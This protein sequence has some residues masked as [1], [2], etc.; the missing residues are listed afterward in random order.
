MKHTCHD[1]FILSHDNLSGY[2][3][4]NL[5][6]ESGLFSNVRIFKEPSDIK[7]VIYRCLFLNE[8]IKRKT[9]I[10]TFDC[11]SNGPRELPFFLKRLSLLKEYID[12]FLLMP[13]NAFGLQYIYKSLNNTIRIISENENLP[14]ILCKLKSENFFEKELD[15]LPSFTEHELKVFFNFLNNPLLPCRNRLKYMSEYII[16][17]RLAKKIG[18]TNRELRSCLY[19]LNCDYYIH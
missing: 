15:Y 3:L 4:Y 6:L 14:S 16:L 19:Q 5:C 18:M 9:V 11:G 1:V 2:G 7:S 12:L 13:L 8:E 10:V 17:D